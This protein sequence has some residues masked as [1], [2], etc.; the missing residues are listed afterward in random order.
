MIDAKESKPTHEVF[1]QARPLQD[2]NAYLG[3]LGLREAVAHEGA[4][5]FD[6]RLRTYGAIAGSEILALGDRV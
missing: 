3:D 1:N 6:E 2:Y 4:A 5:A